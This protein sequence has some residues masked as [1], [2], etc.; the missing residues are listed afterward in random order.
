MWQVIYSEIVLPGKLISRGRNLGR[1]LTGWAKVVGQ[2]VGQKGKTYSQIGLPNCNRVLERGNAGAINVHTI[3]TEATEM[4][5]V[6]FAFK[7]GKFRVCGN[8]GAK[9]YRIRSVLVFSGVISQKI[10]VGRGHLQRE[11]GNQQQCQRTRIFARMTFWK[12]LPWVR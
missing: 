9:A 12:C 1:I 11:R 2:N 4:E 5:T 8:A 10:I 7:P 6:Q 3:G